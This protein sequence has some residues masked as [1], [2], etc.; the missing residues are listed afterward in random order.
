[1]TA[2]YAF[3]EDFERADFAGFPDRTNSNAGV[4]S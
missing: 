2:D 3:I 1:M 4:S